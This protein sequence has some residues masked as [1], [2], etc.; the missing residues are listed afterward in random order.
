MH[1]IKEH[2]T[3]SYPKNVTCSEQLTQSHEIINFS[4]G[5]DLGAPSPK[6]YPITRRCLD[7]E[8][9]KVFKRATDNMINLIS[10]EFGPSHADKV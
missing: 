6:T 5:L 2:L 4:Q 7:I 10:K 9:S 8:K 3:S 1:Q